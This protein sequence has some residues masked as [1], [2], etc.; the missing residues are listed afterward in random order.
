V[1][2]VNG[3]AA[4]KSSLVLM[5]ISFNGLFELY[6][7]EYVKFKIVK[8]GENPHWLFRSFVGTDRL[9][10]GRIVKFKDGSLGNHQI[11]HPKYIDWFDIPKSLVEV[12]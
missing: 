10:D 11:K 12:Y 2:Q 3:F 1:K 4:E 7:F 8:V 5:V 9:L 6:M